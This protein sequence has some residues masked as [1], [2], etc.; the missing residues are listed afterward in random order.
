MSLLLEALKK[1]ALEKQ[2]RVDATPGATPR[3]TPPIVEATPAPKAAETTEILSSTNADSA[4]R[5]VMESRA[6]MAA[7]ESEILADNLENEIEEQTNK[8]VATDYSDPD[9]DEAPDNSAVLANEKFNDTFDQ[10]DEVTP[11]TE[12]PDTTDAW[13]ELEDLDFE[14]E[15]ELEVG[16]FDF[17]SKSV[18]PSAPLELED[19]DQALKEAKAQQAALLQQQEAENARQLAE[20]ESRRA[21]EASQQQAKQSRQA[22]DQ[23]IASGKAVARRSKRRA[24]FL[25]AMLI[26]TAIGGILSYYFYLLANS[27]IAELKQPQFIESEVDIAGIIE[28]TQLELEEGLE[29]AISQSDSDSSDNTDNLELQGNLSKDPVPPE[30]PPQQRLMDSIAAATGPL[31]SKTEALVASRVDPPPSA[32][33]YLRPLISSEERG[34]QSTNMSERVIIHHQTSSD[35]LG[36]VL[37]DAYSALQQKN[38]PAAARLYGQAL[39]INPNQRDALLGAASTATA[40]GRYDDATVYYQR[41]LNADPSDSFAR[42][43][44]LGLMNDGKSR[45]AV[46][47]EVA[48]LLENNPDSPQLHFLKGVGFAA[49]GRW[50][51]A[52]SAFYDAYSFDND[53]PDYAFNLAVSLDHL[54]QPPLAR[55]YYERAL[56]LSKF[57]PTNF[58][59]KA[60]EQRLQELA[61]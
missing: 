22:L 42:A 25:Y 38:L 8:S 34:R 56:N 9:L 30:T 20:G 45:A 11:V 26:M 58:D 43:G 27:S 18:T 40:Q 24:V 61:Q 5:E 10:E 49:E 12:E 33:E 57:R 54:R 21:S 37:K 53:N 32:S 3:P 6:S 39:A 50:Q 23:L 52:Q 55:V 48:T 51:Q 14:D 4:I 15:E 2:N 47:R 35:K 16:N 13:D 46:Q 59:P 1:A 60:I 41:R 17:E 7:E 44:M 29:A 19:T 28:A 36:P 31:V